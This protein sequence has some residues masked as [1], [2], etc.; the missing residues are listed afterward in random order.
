MSV[1][2]ATKVQHFGQRFWKYRLQHLPAPKPGA[3]AAATC[4]QGWPPRLMGQMMEMMR[5]V[6]S[7]LSELLALHSPSSRTVLNF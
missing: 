6:F 7:F 3:K 4:G 2:L 1:E 5:G